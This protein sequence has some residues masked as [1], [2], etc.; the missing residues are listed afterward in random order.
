MYFKYMSKRVEQ[1][2]KIHQESLDVFIRKNKD[3]GDAFSKYGVVGEF[4]SCAAAA[5]QA[6]WCDGHSSRWWR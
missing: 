1:L 2:K 4:K 5:W 6:G 3:Y